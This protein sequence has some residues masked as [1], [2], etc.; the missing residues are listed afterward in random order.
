M[1][2]SAWQLTGAFGLNHLEQCSRPRVEL[3]RQD[4]R[5]RMRASSLN[6]RDIL[7]V[8]GKY[9][10]KLALPFV[11][12]SDGVGEVIEIGAEVVD[13]A[14]GDRVIPLF[15]QHWMQGD[16]TREDIAQHTLGGPLDGTL[17]E[18]FVAPDHAVVRIPNDLSNETAATL[19]C[20]GLTAWSALVE[21]GD[22]CDDSRVLIEGT[23]GVSL[24]AL[25]IAKALGAHVFA[26]SSSDDKCAKLAAL[27]ADETHNYNKDPNWGKAARKWSGRGVDLVVD[28]G[29]AKTFPQALAA[30][31][32]G[33][34]VALI[35][36]LSGTKDE[37]DLI[38]IL[39]NQI[40]VQGVFV[41]HR[42]G[43]EAFVRFVDR[44]AIEPVIDRR[45][46]FSE[47][48]TAFEHV[49]AARHIGKVVIEH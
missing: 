13:F 31:R 38:P 44:T 29:G 8:E 2:F 20:A 23:G 24:F 16:P 3:S 34:R 36:V 37:F 10:P 39:M 48:K 15:T 6:Y 40:R 27:G 19:P 7:M 1:A 28:I 47:A 9:N 17:T 30:V 5:L 49:Q 14:V 4:V 45:F 11:P 18:E 46:A 12:L 25:Q 32:P 26:I 22:I 41:G 21:H 35:G 33:G 43:L 42:A